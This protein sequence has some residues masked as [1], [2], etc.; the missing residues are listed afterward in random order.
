MN[1]MKYD[2]DDENDILVIYEHNED[3]KESLEV[4]EGIVLDLDSDDGVVGI[5]IMDASEFFGS[6]NPEINK[7]FL[8]ELNSARIEYK[9]F[10]NQW[11]LLVVLQS[12][13]KQFSQPMPPLRKTEFASQ[14]LHIIKKIGRPIYSNLYILSIFVF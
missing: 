3:V 7:S 11:M 8:S 2:Y 10:R 4:S 13:G 12:K 1:N 9:S 14:Y 5:E 6:F